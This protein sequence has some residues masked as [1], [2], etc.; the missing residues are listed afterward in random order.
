MGSINFLVRLNPEMLAGYRESE[1]AIIEGRPIWATLA[2]AIGVF[3][4][5]IGSLLLQVRK[6]AAFYILM[7]SLVGIGATQIYRF[8]IGLDFSVGEML[9]IVLTPI[10]VSILLVWYSNVVEGKGW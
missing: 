3:G 9:G 4:A 1:R 6:H 5:F 10:A 2:F 8:T 7:L